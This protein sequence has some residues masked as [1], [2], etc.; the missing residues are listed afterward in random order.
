MTEKKSFF[1]P[2]LFDQQDRNDSS[3]NK[4]E[5]HAR[6]SGRLI[7]SFITFVSN[8]IVF[9]GE[10]RYIKLSMVAVT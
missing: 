3:L 6:K 4:R 8:V 1:V 2:F 5:S 10:V 7:N 9:V